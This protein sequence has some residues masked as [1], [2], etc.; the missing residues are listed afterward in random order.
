MKTVLITRPQGSHRAL[1]AQLEKVGYPVCHRPALAIE[2]LPVSNAS[3]RVLM[4][5]DHFQVVFFASANAAGLALPAMAD[6]WPQWPVGVHWLA[7]GHATAREMERWHLDPVVPASGFNSE[8][9]LELDCMQDLAEQKVLICRGDGGRPLLADTLQARGAEVTKLAFYRR[10][11]VADFAVPDGVRWVM[12][13]SIESWQAMAHAVPGH[14]TVIAAGERVAEAI[15]GDHDGP[16]TVAD[17]AHD[18][19]MIQAL[20]E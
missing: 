10:H 5:L 11:P 9:I 3:R 6:V 7:V 2:P 1:Q 12:V 16:V 19:D 8:A 13:T 14:C 17:S 4:D 18:A 20:P 15:R